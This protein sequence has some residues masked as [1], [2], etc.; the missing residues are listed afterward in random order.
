MP[1]ADEATATGFDAK[2]SEYE[3]LI[4]AISELEK[5]NKVKICNIRK[6]VNSGLKNRLVKLIGSKPLFLC[7][8]DGEEW[9]VLWDCGSQVCVVDSDWLCAHA[10]DAVLQP[11]S[12][13]L[14]NGEK[15]EF[16]AANNTEVPM[17]G[18]VVLQF[19]LGSV[20][21][22]VPFVVTSSKI[23]QPIIGFNVMEHVI[24]MGKPDTIV[25]SLQKSLGSHIA[26]GTINVMVDLISRNF[27]DSDCV[28]LL[29]ATKNVNIPAGGVA[30]L[31]CRI[32]GDVRGMDLSFICSAPSGGLGFRFGSNE[33]VR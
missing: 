16:L 12:D 18:A 33:L 29:K 19:T 8:L 4:W 20:T 7:K 17:L 9:K 5:R 26:V 2:S 28:G 31:K 25:S 24:C 30:R 1:V 32:K 11:I 21:F 3:K 6:P 22:P 27:E 13:F 10:P 14:D 15:I 23:A